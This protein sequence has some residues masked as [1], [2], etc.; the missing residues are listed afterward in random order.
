MEITFHLEK[1]DG[2]LDLL[3]SLISKNKVSIID[4]PI[5]QI[6]E[7]YLEYLEKM[8]RFDMHISADFVA[9][10]AQLT[11]IKSKMLLPRYDDEE[12]DPRESLVEA[13]LEY[14]RVKQAGERLGQM[15]EAGRDIFT[16]APEAPHGS[17]SKA[18]EGNVDLSALVKAVRSIIERSERA[19]PPRLSKFSGIVG[20]EKVSVNDKIAEI[21]RLFITNAKLSLTQLVMSAKS[22]SDIVAV[23][24]AVLELA[25]AHKIEIS[26]ENDDY[27]LTLSPLSTGSELPQYREDEDG[28]S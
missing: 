10:A 27:T 20:R 24:L 22:R 19:M 6:L 13:L 9:M 4:I 16:K 12:E 26:E 7:Q 21:S 18:F 15:G 2:P 11:Y 14:Q 3:L 17:K 28:V 5:A 23:F 1:F 8:K 25:K